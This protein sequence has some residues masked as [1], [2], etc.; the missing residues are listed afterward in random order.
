MSNTI[1]IKRRVSG[2]A[3]S[4]DTLLNGELAFNE[5]DGNLFYGGSSI[6]KIGGAGNLLDKSTDQVINGDKTF[7]DTV[8]F[9][10]STVAATLDLSYSDN[11]VATTEFV[12]NAFTIVDGG[13]FDT[14]ATT[15][16]TRYY[17]YPAVNSNWFNYN[18]WFTDY[19]HN[20]NA[21]GLPTQSNSVTIIGGVSINI[22]L[23]SNNYNQPD[24]INVGATNTL[25]FSSQNTTN[26]TSKI[27][28]NATFNGNLIY[29]A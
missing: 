2:E 25:S 20:V 29:Q 3:G 28:G 23:D 26:I 13:Y 9:S 18:N 15:Y 27:I 19:K 11:N 6:K 7:D 12:H 24:S 21:N 1:L 17:F 16:I 14:P 22:N 4:P 8:E 10:L 5:V